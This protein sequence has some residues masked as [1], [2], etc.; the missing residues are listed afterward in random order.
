MSLTAKIEYDHT[1]ILNLLYDIEKLGTA[2]SELRAPLLNKCKNEIL[3]LAH[4]EEEI[5]HDALAEEGV[6]P[7]LL[8]R[9]SEENEDIAGLLHALE[10][11]PDE[12]KEWFKLFDTLKHMVMRHI[13]VEETKLLPAVEK[14]LQQSLAELEESLLDAKNRQWHI[15]LSDNVIS[16]SSDFFTKARA[17]KVAA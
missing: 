17:A 9:L 3:I 6:K 10:H 7:K 11:T 5:L 13:E 16:L 1:K 12:T 14:T 2:P 15:D 4:A 8:E